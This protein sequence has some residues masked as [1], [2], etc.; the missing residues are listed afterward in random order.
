M[1]L[2]ITLQ[3]GVVPLV[4][5]SLDLDEMAPKSGHNQKAMSAQALMQQ[6]QRSRVSQTAAIPI[7]NALTI[8]LAFASITRKLAQ[9]RRTPRI[10]PLDEACEA[11][12][13]S[14]QAHQ[15]YH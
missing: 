2:L 15:N 4:P 5:T 9:S 13:M 7:E 10:R 12:E 1:D 3:S 6:L 8:P 14:T 11:K